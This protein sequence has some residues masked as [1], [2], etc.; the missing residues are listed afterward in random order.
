MGDDG[1]GGNFGK[2]IA[3]VLPALPPLIEIVLVAA[4]LHWQFPSPVTHLANTVKHLYFP[5]TA[6]YA[7]MI[8]INNNITPPRIQIFSYAASTNAE[9]GFAGTAA[10]MRFITFIIK[11]MKNV[12]KNIL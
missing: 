3:S 7:I 12:K 6:K 1:S 10:A 9:T 8:P 11:M 4:V 2:L 5:V